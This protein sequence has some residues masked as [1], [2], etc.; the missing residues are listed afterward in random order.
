M[1]VHLL[2]ASLYDSDEKTLQ[3]V[4]RQSKAGSPY[5]EEALIA[6]AVAQ[7]EVE[8]TT[9]EAAV[10]FALDHAGKRASDKTSSEYKLAVTWMPMSTRKCLNR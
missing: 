10:R 1:A 8:A 7:M 5:H 3:F 9:L 2:H 4:K 6:Y